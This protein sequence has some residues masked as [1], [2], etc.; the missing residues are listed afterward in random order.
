M[1]IQDLGFILLFLLLLWRKNSKLAAI[2]GLACLVFAIPLFG[3][4]IML[5]TAERL[6]WYA[7]AF[8]LYAIIL[9][10]IKELKG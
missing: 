5:F 8:F 6:T 1:K 7:A 4:K 3:F 2:T 9:L 10:F